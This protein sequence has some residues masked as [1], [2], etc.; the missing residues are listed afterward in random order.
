VKILDPACGSGNFLYVT[1][2]LLKG[3]ESEVLRRLEDVTGVAQLRLDI[4]Q[5]NPSQ[6]N[7][8]IRWL[9]PDYQAPG[10]TYVQPS[11]AGIITETEIAIAPTEQQP[12]PKTLKEQLSAIRDLF[13]TQSGEWTAAQVTAHFKGGNR[14]QK[15]I[16]DCLESLENLGILLSHNENGITFWHL[17]EIENPR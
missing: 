6:R 12:F 1:L 2:D 4:D 9:R 14:K 17:T 8:L 11:L 15:A 10:E 7:G 13:R 3:L 16:L 5:V